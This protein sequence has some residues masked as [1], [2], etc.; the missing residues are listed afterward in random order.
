MR[1]GEELRRYW[2][3]VKAAQ[4]QYTFGYRPPLT[5]LAS[6]VIL[7]GAITAPTAM[8]VG[9]LLGHGGAGFPVGLA[10]AFPLA[11]VLAPTAKHQ[12]R[13]A[14]EDHWEPSR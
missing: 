12:A 6:L 5:V 10:A 3:W 4:D 9:W 14:R 7:V 2:Q 11:L 8:L 1:A 13:K